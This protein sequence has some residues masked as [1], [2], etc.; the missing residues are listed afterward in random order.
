MCIQAAQRARDDGE[1]DQYY[2]LKSKIKR[3]QTLTEAAAVQQEPLRL[4]PALQEWTVVDGVR[5]KHTLETMVATAANSVGG[6]SGSKVGGIIINSC[7]LRGS[8]DPHANPCSIDSRVDQGGR[9]GQMFSFSAADGS[10]VQEEPPEPEH[11][12]DAIVEPF[13]SEQQRQGARGNSAR[14]LSS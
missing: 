9:G 5:Q 4:Q 3:L 11:E 10:L 14:S 1:D 2:S 6:A 13:L 7:Y 8:L 12:K